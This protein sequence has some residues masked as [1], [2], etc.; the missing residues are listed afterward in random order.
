LRR[1][2]LGPVLLALV[3]RLLLV[4]ATDRVVA[5]VLRYERM[6]RHLLDVSWN[7]YETKRL[8]PYPPPWAAVEAGAEWLARH[9]VGSFPVDVKLPVVAADLAIVALLAVAAGAGRASPLAPWL[10]AVHPVSL[11]VTGVHGQFDAVMLAFVL[12]SLEAL[13]RGRR[14]AS[15]LALAGAIAT[16][17]FPVLLLPF[18]ALAGGATWRKGARFAVL[19]TLPVAALLVP[20]AL[21]NLEALRRELF[22]YSGVADFG[23]TGLARGIEWLATGALPRSEA[24]YWPAAA[25]ASKALFLGGWVALFLASKSGRLVLAPTRACLAVLLSFGV[26]Y[27]SQSAQYLLW[28]VPL[29]VMQPDRHAARYAVA[30]TFGLV[31][32]YLFLA[33]GVLVPGPLDGGALRGAG[34]VWVA[35]VA[36]VLV[37]SAAW[38]AGVVSEGLTPGFR[39][40]TEARWRPSTS[41]S[42]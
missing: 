2:L 9:G 28:V 32:F 13:A 5:D 11:L 21:A 1:A 14:D 33:P 40:A 27:G 8:Y 20:F 6:G 3:L 42:R 7:P 18:L 15:A 10:Y 26:L 37:V 25:T 17:S 31:G 23:W 16:K 24:P 19:A 4:F 38:L 39:A 36:A 12:L 29:G 35:G 41:P 22:G 34:L 30:A